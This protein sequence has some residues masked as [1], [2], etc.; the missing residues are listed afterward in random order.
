MSIAQHV[1]FLGARRR[2]LIDFESVDL[3]KPPFQNSVY[4][5]VRGTLAITGCEVRLL[6]LLY[7]ARP[8]YWSI[9]VTAIE[10]PSAVANTF[11][12]GVA[13]AYEQSIPLDGIL[14]NH[15]IILIGATTVKQIKISELAH[16]RSSLGGEKDTELRGFTH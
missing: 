16:W 3:R 10:Q 14:G 2:Q 8:D 11:K 15:G 4:L 1:R 9:M 7:S 12:V 6:P 13:V 5:L